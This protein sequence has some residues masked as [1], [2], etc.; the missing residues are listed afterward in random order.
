[1][2][3]VLV[4]GAGPAGYVAALR[5]AQL[6]GEV[7]LVERAQ[8]GGT[9]LNRGCIPTKAYLKS[10]EIYR[11]V[12]SAAAYGIGTGGPAVDFPS[13][14]AR[15]DAVIRQLGRGIQMLLKK[16][17]VRLV[18]G[19]ACFLSPGEVRVTGTAG[20]FVCTADEILIAT[21]SRPSAPPIPGLEGAGVFDSDRVFDFPGLPKSVLIVGGG[22]IGMEFASFY[23]SLGTDVTVVELLDRLLPGTDGEISGLVRKKLE[24]EGVTFR[25][26]SRLL[27]VESDFDGTVATVE[28][29]AGTE[30][31]LTDMVLVAAGRRANCEGLRPEAAGLR[32]EQ[33]CLVTDEKGRTN[34]PHIYAAGD[35]TG[36]I[37][38]AHAASREAEIAVE[39]MFGL[40]T[41][42]TL[43]A[44]PGCI[45]TH[46]EIAFAGLT[47]EDAQKAGY[48]TRIGRFP[49][50]ANGKALIEGEPDGFV[51]V[52]ADAVSGTL[53]GV[54][55]VGPQASNLIGAGAVA[56]S[57][58]MT[59]G[60]FA[61]TV[62]A[63]PTLGEALHE[64]ALDA[65][66]RA[67]HIP[68]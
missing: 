19:T 27:Q 4:I 26:G 25:L 5:A 16:S 21:G 64:A 43:G 50:A 3:K 49:F 28:G 63:H 67:L 44:V 10:A 12:R 7:T 22:V 57:A 23:A 37:Q 68:N 32:T 41:G 47:E 30:E 34:V 40:D 39:E 58:H 2:R 6:G 65:E 20:D 42:L 38:L 55:I 66:K 35:V 8:V 48:Q 62:F 13:I 60:E 18:E 36:K 53:L 51:K 61:N 31:L 24:G 11:Q 45:F 29:D 59:V 17:G 14:R 33:G 52:V 56:L 15:K 1:M 46:P 54:H 9:C